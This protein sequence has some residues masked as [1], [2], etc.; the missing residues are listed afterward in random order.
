MTSPVTVSP[1]PRNAGRFTRR[2]SPDRN[3]HLAI[4]YV[5]VST[6][7][8]ALGPEAQKAAIAVFCARQ[9]YTLGGIYEDI[10]VSGTVPCESRPGFHDAIAAVRRE[11]AGAF[12]VAKLDRLA[13]DMVVAAVATSVITSTGCSFLSAAGE[14]TDRDD[15]GSTLL[16]TLLHAFA[17]H[18]RAMIAFRTKSA[19]RVKIARGERVG[20]VRY[21]FTQVEEPGGRRTGDGVMR[22][23]VPSISERETAWIVRHLVGERRFTARRA[24][25][26]LAGLGYLPR[27]GKPTWHPQQIMRLIDAPTDGVDE[28]AVWMRVTAYVQANP[29]SPRASSLTI[30]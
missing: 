27:T 21:G 25:R 2:Q 24:G 29:E 23:L 30:G 20:A 14:G 15:P 16:S 18:E 22:R 4:G 26:V 10:G 17:A 19:L 12:V 8:Q 7:E 28:H 13:R 6:D 3:I 11:R 1:R 9:G 5:R